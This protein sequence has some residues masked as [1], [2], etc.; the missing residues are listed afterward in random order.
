MPLSI[1]VAVSENNVIGK[2][3]EIPWYLPADLKHFAKTTQ[4]HSVIMGRK[5]YDSILQKL[6]KPLPKRKNI[7]ITRQKD[8][9]LPDCTVV[10]TLEEAVQASSDGEIFVIGGAEIYK[11]AFPFTNKLYLTRVHTKVNG[12]VFFPEFKKDEWKEM[13]S[14]A[15]QAD[16]KN[17]FEYT[18]Y[19]YERK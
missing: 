8:L 19:H 5:T 9:S 1:I 3:G 14:E 11:L 17:K 7:I 4:G 6:G 12:D 2:T 13:S 15:H 10:A 16:E 18:F